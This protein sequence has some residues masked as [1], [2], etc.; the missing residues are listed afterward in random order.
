MINKIAVLDLSWCMHRYR[1]ANED[2]SAIVDGVK[3][4]TGHIYGTYKFV[5]WLS[6]NYKRVLLAVDSKPTIRKEI[7]STYKS[8]RVKNTGDPF[9]DYPIHKDD[10]NILAICTSLEN[11]YYIKCDG[12]EADDIIATLIKNAN[13]EWDFYFHDDDILQ[14]KGIYNLCVSYDMTPKTGSPVSRSEHIEKKYGLLMKDYLPMIWKI[15]KGDSGDCIP[16]ALERFPTKDLIEICSVNNI[17]S[18]SSF[19]EIISA[20]KSHEYKGVWKERI[21]D[22]ENKGSDSYKKLYL[23]YELVRPRFLENMERKKFE[24]ENLQSIFNKYCIKKIS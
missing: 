6:D 23:N 9:M 17:T 10:N 12:Y 3:I 2:L 24:V 22:I 16:I 13:R 8:N 1:H 5:K 7:L 21:K 4:P 18:E 20:I 19:E 14:T 11:V 15:I